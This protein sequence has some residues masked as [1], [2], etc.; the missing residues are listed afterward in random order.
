MLDLRI[1]VYDTTPK[2]TPTLR[3]LADREATSNST[4]SDRLRSAGVSILR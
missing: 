1:S 2:S 3:L 4:A